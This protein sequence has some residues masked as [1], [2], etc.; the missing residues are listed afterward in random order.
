VVMGK[1]PTHHSSLSSEAE[2]FDALAA[3]IPTRLRPRL[4]SAA[5]HLV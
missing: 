5:Q 3:M 2:M 4:A 1:E